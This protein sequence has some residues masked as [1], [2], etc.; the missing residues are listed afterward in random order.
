MSYINFIGGSDL[1]LAHK[2]ADRCGLNFK[3]LVI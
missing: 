3:V 2:L 1:T